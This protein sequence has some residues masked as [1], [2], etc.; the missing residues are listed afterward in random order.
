MSLL[1]LFFFCCSLACLSYYIIQSFE[2]PGCCTWSF[3]LTSVFRS[4]ILLYQHFQAETFNWFWQNYRTYVLFTK[5]SLKGW[6]HNVLSL[7]KSIRQ[8]PMNSKKKFFLKVL[9]AVIIPPVYLGHLKIAFGCAFS[10]NSWG[11]ILLAHTQSYILS[12]N[13]RP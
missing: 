6:V 13:I 7:S 11:R 3:D 12:Y 4:F 1:P 8:A 2:Y 10:I 9:F 5:L